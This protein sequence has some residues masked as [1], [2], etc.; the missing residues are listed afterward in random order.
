MNHPLPEA[1]RT[2]LWVG[3]GICGLL[4]GSFLNVVIFRLPRECMSIVR[5]RSRCTSC[6]RPIPWHENIPILSYI[7]LGGRCRGCRAPIG[8]RYPIV[9]ATTGAMFFLLGWAYLWRTWDPARAALLA[10]AGSSM[11]ALSVIDFDFKILPD[12]IT[13]PGIAFGLAVGA[14]WPEWHG[15]ELPPAIADRNLAGLLA[16]AVG[17]A[18]GFGILWMLRVFGQLIFGGI[19]RWRKFPEDHAWRGEVMGWGDIKLM[20]GIGALVGWKGALIVLIIACFIGSV[21]GA[22]QLLLRRGREI[23]FGPYLCAGGAVMLLFRTQVLEWIHGFLGAL[24]GT[25]Y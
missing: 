4:V 25:P 18:T 17:A 23:P 14:A 1:A 5:P 15:A 21:A 10:V 22:S 3:S 6:L 12:E 11:L 20:G 7:A 8:L 9:E 24:A 13:I 2:V 19:A 16:S